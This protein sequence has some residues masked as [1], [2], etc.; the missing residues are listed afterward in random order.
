MCN[1]LGCA[2]LRGS[3]AAH[4]TSSSGFARCSSRRR[5]GLY[6]HTA[7][8]RA[9]GGR[10][11]RSA[12]RVPRGRTGIG[13]FALINPLSQAVPQERSGHKLGERKRLLVICETSTTFKEW[14]WDHRGKYWADQPL[15]KLHQ[16]EYTAENTQKDLSLIFFFLRRTSSPSPFFSALYSAHGVVRIT[17]K[18]VGKAQIVFPHVVAQNEQTDLMHTFSV[19]C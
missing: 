3:G 2:S 6:M 9:R 15:F 12:R 7:R 14:D 8:R 18:R 16:E 10:Q 19:G 11:T 1:S 17:G 13:L 5:A 4:P